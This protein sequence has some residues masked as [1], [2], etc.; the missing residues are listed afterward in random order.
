MYTVYKALHTP[1]G[2]YYVG[3]TSKSIQERIGQHWGTCLSNR[4]TFQHY[5]HST[6]M[7]EWEWIVLGTVSTYKEARDC[8]MYY[9]KTLNCY[10]MGL[11]EK[12]GAKAPEKRKEA[13]E[14]MKAYKAANPEPWHKGRIKVYSEES[15]E[16]MRLAKLRNPGTYER[17]DELKDE[18][19]K[20][21]GKRV[22]ELKSGLEFDSIS[23]AAIHFNLKR[24]AV[25]DVVNGKRSHTAGLVFVKA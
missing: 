3:Y 9:I 24:E 20:R 2:K 23:K 10:D 14:R 16:K 17:T 25:R 13:S 5:L 4:N 6:L 18:L 1:T 21:Y 8:E 15:L 7:S 12:T 22:K 19:S 11:N